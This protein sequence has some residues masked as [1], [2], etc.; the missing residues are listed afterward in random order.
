MHVVK[1]EFCRVAACDGNDGDD[2][3]ILTKRRSKNLSAAGIHALRVIVVGGKA[4][5][6]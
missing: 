6:E 1:E 2:A 5:G 3:S 4:F